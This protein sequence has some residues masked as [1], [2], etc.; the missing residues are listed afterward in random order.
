MDDPRPGD[1]QPA[2]AGRR[3]Q[4]DPPDRPAR[5]AVDPRELPVKRPLPLPFER[6][7]ALDLRFLRLGELLERPAEELAGKQQGVAAAGRLVGVGVAAVVVSTRMQRAL[8][9]GPAHQPELGHQAVA[10]GVLAVADPPGRGHAAGLLRRQGR[11]LGQLVRAVEVE[12]VARLVARVGEDRVHEHV[13]PAADE[14]LFR[15]RQ[16][17]RLAG[18]VDRGQRHL[19]F[20]P[21][22]GPD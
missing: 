6:I 16:H 15:Q 10:A 9:H 2:V 17:R 3:R 20:R 13:D 19:G 1:H 22:H 8:R 11:P 18:G 4:R 7:L 12:L 21:G 14:H 5:G